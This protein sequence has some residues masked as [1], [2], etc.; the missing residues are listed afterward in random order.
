M[1]PTIQCKRPFVKWVGHIT[2]DI[3]EEIGHQVWLLRR[4]AGDKWGGEYHP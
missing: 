4:F 2:Y 1:V 3:I